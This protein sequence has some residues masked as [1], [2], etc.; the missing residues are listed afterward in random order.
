MYDRP[1]T[2][3]ERVRAAGYPKPDPDY[4]EKTGG[5]HHKVGNPNLFPF[6]LFFVAIYLLFPES[7]D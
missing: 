7:P 3:E 4:W 2:F 5:T 6:F 1:A